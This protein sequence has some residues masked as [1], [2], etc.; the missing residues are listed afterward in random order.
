M[1]IIHIDTVTGL[2]LDTEMVLY[3]PP[4][5][6]LTQNKDEKDEAFAIRCSAH[7]YKQRWGT[8]KT[9]Y[10]HNSNIFITG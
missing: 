2:P 8:P 9:V 6:A 7:E 4:Y 10:I 3:S 5:F 1:K